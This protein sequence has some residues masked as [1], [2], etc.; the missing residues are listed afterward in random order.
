[1]VEVPPR[2]AKSRVIIILAG[3]QVRQF[4]LPDNDLRLAAC[5][6]DSDAPGSSQAQKC[7]IEARNADV[8]SPK[9]GCHLA[10]QGGSRGCLWRIPQEK[11]TG[12]V[13]R[14]GYAWQLEKLSGPILIQANRNYFYL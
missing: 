2:Q 4:H 10:P 11:G 7:G 14:T 8:R 3:R 9:N 6:Q 5:Y 1:M 12:G 13:T